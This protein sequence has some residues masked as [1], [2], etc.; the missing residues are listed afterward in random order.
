MSLYNQDCSMCLR[1]GDVCEVALF[2]GKAMFVC[3]LK[4]NLI[5]FV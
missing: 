2:S 1:L 3:Y 4:L 5:W